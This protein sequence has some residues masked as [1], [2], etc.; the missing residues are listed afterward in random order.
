MNS[1]PPGNNGVTEH[2]ADPWS[3]FIRT[4][5]KSSMET[6]SITENVYELAEE[7]NEVKTVVVEN[8]NYHPLSPD[9]ED[10]NLVGSA[11]F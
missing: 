9:H 10:L 3:Q 11:D 2:V 1:R 8:Q 5:I 4:K 6:S 7:A